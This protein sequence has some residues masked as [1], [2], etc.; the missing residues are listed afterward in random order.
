VG[1]TCTSESSAFVTEEFNPSTLCYTT[2]AEV[3][4][5]T[6]VD[7]HERCGVQVMARLE[8]SQREN[9]MDQSKVLTKSENQNLL[10]E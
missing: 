1:L 6:P 8:F 2:A 7:L 4:S 9:Q 5:D 3:I 10:V